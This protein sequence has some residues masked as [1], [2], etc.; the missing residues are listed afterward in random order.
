M[1][2]TSVREFKDDMVRWRTSLREE[3]KGL[4]V[5]R[6][7][8]D[9]LFIVDRLENGGEVAMLVSSNGDFKYFC[10]GCGKHVQAVDHHRC[11]NTKLIM[12]VRLLEK[13]KKALMSLDIL[14]QTLK[15]DE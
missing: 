1:D 5:C 4:A 6:K 11:E 2:E 3:I 7:E 14:L 12:K 8:D 10:Y 9:P 13:I 15:L